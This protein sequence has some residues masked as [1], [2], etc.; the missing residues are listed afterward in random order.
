MSA[1]LYEMKRKKRKVPLYV[2]FFVESHRFLP[3]KGEAIGK[4]E[5]RAMRE[6]EGQWCGKVN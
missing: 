5:E 4:A 1:A 3:L 6:A 2:I